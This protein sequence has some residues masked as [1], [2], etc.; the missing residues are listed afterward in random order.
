M[1]TLCDLDFYLQQ[2]VFS[3][4]AVVDLCNLLC[5]SKRIQISRVPLKKVTVNGFNVYDFV[6]WL[7]KHKILSIF[8]LKIE[9]Y[10]LLNDHCMTEYKEEN[11]NCIK[12]ITETLENLDVNTLTLQDVDLDNQIIHWNSLEVLYVIDCRFKTDWINT[13]Q[14]LKKLVVNNYS[15]YYFPE[16]LL[17]DQIILCGLKLPRL[18]YFETNGFVFVDQLND[19]LE[20][21]D[22]IDTI[23]S[24][25]I[26]NLL[27]S[28]ERYTSIASD[29]KKKF[30]NA[31]VEI[32]V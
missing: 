18:E 30:K 1:N 29:V 26:Q 16:P 21:S 9:N 24:F 17:N 28:E 14:K 31:E 11:C 23:R 3:Y 13:Q 25:R 19:F 5:V 32:Y 7:K 6:L 8:S 2:N 20:K 12:T 22:V 27:D 4:C 15:P 10:Y